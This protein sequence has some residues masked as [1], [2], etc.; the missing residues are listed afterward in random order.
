MRQPHTRPLSTL[1]L[2]ALL[3][4]L[5]FTG[6]GWLAQRAAAGQARNPTVSLVAPERAR[7]G[8]PV[9]VQLVADGAVDLAGFQATVAFDGDRLR[10]TG[11]GVHPAFAAPGR[12][13][14]PLGPVLARDH[15]KLGA[16][17][18]PTDPCAARAPADAAQSPDGR[19]GRVP[20]ATLTFYSEQPGR[21]E[22]RLQEIQLV[23]PGGE[24]IEID[25]LDTSFVVTSP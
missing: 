1:P 8:E 6:G 25:R 5:L 3:L 15:V 12:G 17:T 2:L 18:C 11:A 9:E 4:A 19:S 21:Y 14:L 22:L 13:T 20:L 10:L 23:T 7:P 24:L 16:A